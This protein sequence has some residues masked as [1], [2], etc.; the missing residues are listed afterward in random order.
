M[1]TP[2]EGNESVI[3]EE[4]NIEN[5]NEFLIKNS[6]VFLNYRKTNTKREG[7]FVK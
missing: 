3:K 2:Q 7:H 4:Y 5:Q 1:E 6:L